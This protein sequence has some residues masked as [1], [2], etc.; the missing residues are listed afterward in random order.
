M[1]RLDDSE[2]VMPHGFIPTDS[3]VNLLNSRK[4][5]YDFDE[6]HP[7]EARS[8][9]HPAAAVESPSFPVKAVIPPSANPADCVFLSA[10]DAKITASLFMSSVTSWDFITNR[11]MSPNDYR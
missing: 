6:S 7:Q 5:I 11:S 1:E 2:A 4:S 10:E 8:T 9:K 3:S